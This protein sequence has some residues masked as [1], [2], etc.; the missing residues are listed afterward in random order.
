MSRKKIY[1]E[2]EKGAPEPLCCTI[3]RRV[4][5]CEVDAMAIMWHGHYAMLFEDVATELRRGCGLGYKDFFDAGLAAPIVKLCVDFHQPLLLDEIVT[6]TARMIWS[7]AARLNIE[8]EV[9]KE[10]GSLAATGCTVQLFVE[11][12]SRLPCF[13]V[14]DMLVSCRNMWRSDDVVTDFR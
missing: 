3:R 8:Y 11:S 1:F 7:D 9:L 13:T 14:P 6:L 5:F 4:R 12:D 2:R 10:D